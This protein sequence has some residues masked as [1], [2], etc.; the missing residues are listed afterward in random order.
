MSKDYKQLFEKVASMER[1]DMLKLLDDIIILC[2]GKS[3][4]DVPGTCADGNDYRKDGEYDMA[5]EI[6]DTVEN[7]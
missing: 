6:L 7:A 3:P 5:D 1:E 4:S 2:C